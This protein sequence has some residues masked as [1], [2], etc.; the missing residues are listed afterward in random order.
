MAMLV[1]A[2]WV[3]PISRPPI[4]DGAVLVERG[5]IDRVGR[6][7]DFGS[8]V[9]TVATRVDLPGC[10]VMPGLVNAHA[11]LSLTAMEGLLE[12]ADFEV[13]LPRL[14]SA[15]RAWEPGDYAASATLGAR[16]CL[17]A[18]VTVVGD[19]VYGPEGTAAAVDAGLGGTFFWELLGLKAPQLYAELERLEFPPDAQGACGTRVRCGLSP[20]SAYTSGPGFM[21]AVH[22]AAEELGV[23]FAIHV[24]ESR[25]ELDLMMHG[26]GPLADVAAR[27][28]PD[29]EAPGTTP[30]CYLDRIGV[31]DG[32]TA[33]HLCHV[34]P[35][36]I[37]R[38]SATTRGTVT[39]PRSNA[40]L[41]NAHPPIGRLLAHH[42]P[43][44]VGT[45][46][47][48]SNHDLDLMSEVR[49][50]HQ[51]DPSIPATTLLQMATLMGAIALGVE[52]RF[53][54]LETGMQADLAAF[55]LGETID[56]EADL[57][58]RA[59]RQTLAAVCTAG[60]W[61]VRDGRLVDGPDVDSAAEKARARAAEAL[62]GS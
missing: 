9:D 60:K 53:G 8:L 35:T 57:V 30:V 41:G 14:V 37:S 16:R 47:A 22:S 24:A 12:P 6:V 13:W 4:R 59:G 48:A 27:L 49:A 18:G 45:D 50:V 21:R 26:T 2:D 11:H 5:L 3:V 52:D 33:V 42:L 15:M 46:S 32:A 62:K 23:P 43:V 20:H 1:T 10:T 58:K 51:I 17:E 31:M 7:S 38:L 34:S 28:A 36:D 40:F 29:F 25:A 55:C 54:V 56:P 61:R 44:G 19:I 39:C